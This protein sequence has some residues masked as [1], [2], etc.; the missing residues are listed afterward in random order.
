MCAIVG[1]ML[2]NA[3]KK[4]LSESDRVL[5]HITKHSFERGKDGY[6][7]AYFLDRS[8]E[9]VY[10]GREVEHYP[11]MLK[12]A[13]AL[14]L[15]RVIHRSGIFIS[16]IRAEPTTE[17]VRGKMHY[18][19]QPYSQGSWSIVHNGTI[20]NDKELRTYGLSTK[21]D[22]AA[23]AELLDL[24]SE[25]F[26]TPGEAF[27]EAVRRLKGSYAILAVKHGAP[28]RM[29]VATN[30]RPLWY[31]ETPLGVY[32]ASAK[33]YF[34]EGMQ[35]LMVEPYTAIEFAYSRGTLSKL[36]T[37]LRPP[38]PSTKQEK[39]LVVCSGG[40]DSVVA[41]TV[42]QRKLEYDIH[43]LHFMY[44]CRP[45]RYEAE[46][47][48]EAAKAL[49]VNFT[50]LPLNIYQ[51]KD[52]PLLNNDATVAGGE[53]GAEFAHEWVP[54][55]NLVMLSI[56]TAYAEANGYDVVVLGNNMEEAGAYP[57][58]E[59][60]FVNRFNELLPFAVADG[61]RVRVEMPVGNMMKHQIV[62]LGHELGA[63]MDKTWSCYRAG[64]QHCGTC[65]PCFMRKTAFTINNIPEVI[66]YE[67]G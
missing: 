14:T 37:S 67:V 10:E 54:A 8:R 44:G 55:R 7:W 31:A 20:A 42:A 15:P 5:R 56:A 58:N 1:A 38:V 63:P 32:F 21:I 22:S 49:G 25:D 17:W 48:V 53:E 9:L 50:L 6:G 16:N 62:K 41:A 51:K 13:Q 40:L 64:E 52:S 66:P 11:L 47:V 18:D 39:A 24:V 33:A 27:L 61:K 3:T 29:M 19:Q 2:F 45:E 60:E 34:P 28:N 57:D 35:P 12:K 59:P 43:L 23:I 30:Y 36:K 26:D 46:A 4:T 65:G